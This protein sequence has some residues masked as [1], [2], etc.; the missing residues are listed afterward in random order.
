MGAFFSR[1]TACDACDDKDARIELM[2]AEIRLLK[3]LVEAAEDLCNDKHKRIE[4]LQ[5][6]VHSA[7][8]RAIAAELKAM[9]AEDTATQAYDVIR[10]FQHTLAGLKV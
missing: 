6:L 9:D 1:A 10:M 3:A 2:L 4:E 5:D 8:N 7:E